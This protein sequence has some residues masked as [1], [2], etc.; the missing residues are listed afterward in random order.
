MATANDDLIMLD[1]T[2]LGICFKLW[3]RTTL[4]G[5]FVRKLTR[6]KTYETIDHGE[7]WALRHVSFQ[8][9]RGDRLGI[10]GDNGAGKSTL[11][12]ILVGIYPPTEGT[13]SCHATIYPLLQLGL[14]FNPEVTGEENAYLA[15]AF[16]GM[17]K[18][19]VRP[20]LDELFAFSEV[21]DF[22]HRP[23]KTY[24]AGMVGRLAFTLATAVPA[25]LLVLDE[26]FSS[27]DIH[28]TEKAVKRIEAR[29]EQSRAL[30]MV[31][32][33]MEQIRKYCNKC[34]LLEKGR[35]VDLGGTEVVDRY[36]NNNGLGISK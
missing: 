36:Q 32:H 20:L 4:K 18:E 29:I 1:A 16:F 30:I 12:K 34:L 23:L 33:S 21:E 28:W 8:L 26:V 27:G 35:A 11:L 25:D 31:S 10:I 15:M 9:R 6:S 13:V 7:F 24:S 19:Q 14:G 2:D 17:G 22:R 3:T 5:Q